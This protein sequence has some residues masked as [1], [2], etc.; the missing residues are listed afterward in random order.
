MNWCFPRKILLLLKNGRKQHGHLDKMLCHILHRGGFTA[1]VDN[2]VLCLH[3]D[4]R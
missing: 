1:A 2:S 3:G 4:D